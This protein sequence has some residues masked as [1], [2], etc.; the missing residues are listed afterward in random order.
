MDDSDHTR[1]LLL[2]TA[3]KILEEFCSKGVVDAAEAGEW[4]EQLWSALEDSGFLGSVLPE[5]EGGAGLKLADALAPA[6]LAA[7]YAAPIPYGETIIA[8]WVLS[9]AG[10]EVPSGVLTF[11]PAT[12]QSKL[13]FERTTDGWLLSGTLRGIPWGHVAT[14]VALVIT[15][16]TDQYVVSVDPRLAGQ[17]QRTNLAG[18]PR[19]HLK[20]ERIALGDGEVA[21]IPS[22]SR[23]DRS[24]VLGAMLRCL[25]M[26]GALKAACDLAVRYAGE[27]IAFGNPL[28]KLPAV[29]Q[30]LAV[31][32]GQ[33]AAA[34][35][36]AD[37]LLEALLG[38][39][40]A[41]EA[42]VALARVRINEAA[43]IGTRLSHQVHGA[44]GFT[45]E[46]K[47][48]HATRRLWSW[49]DEFG[50]DSHWAERIGQH[51]LEGGA[52]AFWNTVTEVA[53]L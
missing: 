22:E 5:A 10:L 29:Q 24:M 23:F 6:R 43:E 47:L 44:I 11:G 41:I 2:E 15:S 14:R 30:N 53:Q 52:D 42:P 9:R 1:T 4:P 49:R 27:R 19:T 25:Q 32:A 35:V 7:C 17:M 8:S 39:E 33:A 45:Y 37:M 38:D 40:T 36:A 16:A 21:R 34:N 18:E 48:H 26:A 3:G 31:L 51:L 13:E 20:F 46:H 50:N 28:N 12:P